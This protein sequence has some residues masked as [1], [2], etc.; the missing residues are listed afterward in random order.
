[1]SDT[2]TAAKRTRNR[3]ARM[4]IDPAAQTVTF[5]PFKPGTHEPDGRVFT[6]ELS[7]LPPAIVTLLALD[8][9]RNKL[10]DSYADPESDILTQCGE[11]YDMLAAGTWAA[12]RGET[13]ERTT[14]FAEAYA[15]L[16]KIDLE[17]AKARINSILAG[18][19]DDRKRTLDGWR[20]HPQIVAEM[21]S[22]SAAKA[23]ERARVARKA[24][25]G[26]AEPDFADL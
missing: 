17:D 12:P 11:T 7:R 18:D 10:M 2:A 26:T 19:D 16:K 8:R 9:L 15:S 4:Q 25:K 22:I 14:L 21:T 13:A 1:M 23:A 24:A 5:S 20:R 6:A 3:R